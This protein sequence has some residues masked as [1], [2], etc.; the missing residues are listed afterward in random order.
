MDYLDD[1]VCEIQS[2]ELHEEFE[3]EPGRY[4]WDEMEAN[5]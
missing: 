2:D 3:F 1:F 4:Y 5:P